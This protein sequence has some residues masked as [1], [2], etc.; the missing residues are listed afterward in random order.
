[1]GNLIDSK[2]RITLT[3]DSYLSE[4]NYTDGTGKLVT[5]TVTYPTGAPEQQVR[6]SVQ[7]LAA[8]LPELIAYVGVHA[9]HR[10]YDL[11]SR[12]CPGCI[13]RYL[14]RAVARGVADGEL[15]PTTGQDAT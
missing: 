5:L 11:A 12:S 15:R 14:A 10:P 1:M 7:D 3:R 4:R 6:L 13:A 9:R 8:A 2:G